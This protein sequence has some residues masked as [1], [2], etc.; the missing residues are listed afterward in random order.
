MNQVIQIIE[1]ESLELVRWFYFR[2]IMIGTTRSGI[3]DQLID[4]NVYTP[5][6]VAAG[7]L[8]HIYKWKLHNL[9]IEIFSLS[10]R[11]SF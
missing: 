3:S 8:M 7:M 5:C 4:T 2:E 11:F 6:A 10:V 9:K 1:L